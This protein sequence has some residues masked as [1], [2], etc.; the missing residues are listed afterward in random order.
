MA[1]TTLEAGRSRTRVDCVRELG[2]DSWRNRFERYFIGDRRRLLVDEFHGIFSEDSIVSP[3]PHGITRYG[4][5]TASTGQLSIV[6]NVIVQKNVDEMKPKRES[7][8]K[9]ELNVVGLL[10]VYQEAR[11]KLE[12]VS[13]K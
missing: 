13:D 9:K 6:A 4:N 10:S 12:E 11:K 5:K 7:R 2:E 3:H 8:R 1:T